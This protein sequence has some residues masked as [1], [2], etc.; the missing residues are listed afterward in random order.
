MYNLAL[1]RPNPLALFISALLSS[2]HIV[3]VRVVLFFEDLEFKGWLIFAV[4]WFVAIIIN[5]FIA[6]L[7]VTG[8]SAVDGVIVVIIPPTV[9]Y[10]LLKYFRKG[11]V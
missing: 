5:T 6:P 7:I 3:K 4:V 11:E 8:N 10:L 9:L 2:I 1:G